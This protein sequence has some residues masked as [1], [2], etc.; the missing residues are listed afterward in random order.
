MDQDAE[1]QVLPSVQ[2]LENGR[3]FRPEVT[4]GRRMDK[5]ILGEEG[6]AGKETRKE[7]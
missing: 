1:F 6:N 2:F 4:V 3:V 5:G 7:R